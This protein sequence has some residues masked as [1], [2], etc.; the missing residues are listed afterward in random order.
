MLEAC[1]IFHRGQTQSAF[2]KHFQPYHDK[3]NLNN[4]IYQPGTFTGN[5]IL[6]YTITTID[7]TMIISRLNF[8]HDH[9]GTQLNLLGKP[10]E[11]KLRYNIIKIK[12]NHKHC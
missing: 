7:L 2:Q 12:I 10:I 3:Q 6:R 4:I 11:T 9:D 8:H 5:Y 1:S